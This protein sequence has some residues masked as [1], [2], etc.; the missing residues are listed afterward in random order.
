M[1]RISSGVAA[2]SVEVDRFTSDAPSETF[3]PISSQ[4]DVEAIAQLIQQKVKQ[5]KLG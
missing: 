3:A 5:T 1:K 2:E 4:A